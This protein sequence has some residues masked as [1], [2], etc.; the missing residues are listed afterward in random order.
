LFIAIVKVTLVVL[1]AVQSV[2]TLLEDTK[3]LAVAGKA[4]ATRC[5]TAN[6]KV[7]AQCDEL[8]TK[9]SY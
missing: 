1:F 6:V 7:H 4:R 9:L 5:S 2:V 3:E 8:A